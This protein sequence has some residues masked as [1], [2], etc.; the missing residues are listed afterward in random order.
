MNALFRRRAARRNGRLPRPARQAGTDVLRSRSPSPA[1]Q[2]RSVRSP[3]LAVIGIGARVVRRRR[4]VRSRLTNSLAKA[5]A[6]PGACRSAPSASPA[7]CHGKVELPGPVAVEVHDVEN[8]ARADHDGSPDARPTRRRSTPSRRSPRTRRIGPRRR[9]ADRA[10]PAA[11]HCAP[12][13]SDTRRGHARHTT[14]CPGSGSQCTPP[15]MKRQVQAI[16]MAVPA[17]AAAALQAEIPVG[18]WR[19]I[20]SPC[21]SISRLGA[22]QGAAAAR[23][24]RRHRQQ[25]P[26]GEI[27]AAASRCAAPRPPRAGRRRRSAPPAV[28]AAYS[29]ASHA[30]SVGRRARSECGVAGFPALEVGGMRE[31]HAVA[32]ILAG[33]E[34]QVGKRAVRP[35]PSAPGRDVR[36]LSSLSSRSAPAVR[37]HC[38]PTRGRAAR[39]D[40]SS[41]PR[42]TYRRCRS[43]RQGVRR[44]PVRPSIGIDG[45]VLIPK[46]GRDRSERCAVPGLPVRQTL[47]ELGDDRG[48]LVRNRV[49]AAR[50]HRRPGHAFRAA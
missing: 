39:R 24:L 14:R 49:D 21:C 35:E 28:A 12:G 43:R 41:R 3:A 17:A 19:M 10:R 47:V 16:G 34:G 15:A 25:R 50:R 1:N 27:G 30:G 5:S 37:A 29:A 40:D 13:S 46:P 9:P 7:R 22:D 23:Q 6:L 26:P 45:E 4:T 2:R 31:R 11:A 38:R 32:G 18:P 48:G 8:P 36:R 42:T 33:G 20:A 44:R